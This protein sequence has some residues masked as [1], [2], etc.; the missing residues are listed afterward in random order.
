MSFFSSAPELE[1]NLADLK[2]RRGEVAHFQATFSNA[3]GDDEKDLPE[4]AWKREG[5]L[6]NESKHTHMT[7]I[8]NVLHLKILN[9]QIDDTGR[10]TL[11]LENQH[12]AVECSAHLIV[13]GMPVI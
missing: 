11:R 2:I 12:G 1:N 13:Q 10:Y 5:R 8:G 4:V 6:L 3:N 9:S 7:V